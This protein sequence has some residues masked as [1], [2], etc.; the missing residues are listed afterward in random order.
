MWYR[1]P[2]AFVIVSVL[3]VYALLQSSTATLAGR[4]S[5]PGLE[6][7]VRIDRDQ[8]GVPLILAENETDMARALGF[9][10]GQERFFQMDLL[11]RSAAGELAALFGEKALEHD[12]DLRRHRFRARA[13]QNWQRLDRAQQALL[14][15]Y[16]AGVNAGL[17]E[18][19]SRPFEYWL[20]RQQ[21]QAWTV[22]DSLL[23]I[24][25]MYLD[26]QGTL[27]ARE[28]SLAYLNQHW[29]AELVDF[30]TPGGGTLD[31]PL[32]GSRL[33]LKAMPALAW[34]AE[35]LP[36][37]EVTI[38]DSDLL[39]GSNAWAVSGRLT[40]DGR[41]LLA[42]DMHLTLR[43]PNIWYRISARVGRQLRAGLT[44]PGAPA[45]VS[46]SNGHLAW[47]FT[48]AYGD[49]SDL[50]ALEL[51][52]QGHYRT[53]DG[54]EPLTKITE[55]IQVA[56]TEPVTL[57]V[58]ESRWGPV[59]GTLPDG[60]PYAQLWTAHQ[61]DG[62]NLKLLELVHCLDVSCALALAP[63]M[64]IPTQNLVL[65]DRRGNLAWIPAGP[66]P[67]RSGYDGL[68]PVSLADGDKTFALRLPASA[69]PR[70][71]NP[72]T[73][74]IWS[75]NQRMLGGAELERIGDGGYALGARAG[76]IRDRLYA[77]DSFDEQ[78]FFAIQHDDGVPLY[79]YWA[80]RLDAE[81]SLLPPSADVVKARRL[82]SSW[83]QRA[84]LEE[85]AFP[86]IKGFRQ[87]LMKRLFAPLFGLT[88]TEPR[89]DPSPLDNQLE[90]P[91]RQLLNARP[92]SML[93]PG[94]QSWDDLLSELTARLVADHAQA[95]WPT[96]GEQNLSAI[97]HPLSAALPPWLGRYLDAPAAPQSGDAHAPHVS[98]ARF[99]A[100]GRLVVVPGRE[101]NAILVMPGGQS[102]HPLSPYYLAGHDAWLEGSPQPLLAG[103][104]KWRLELQP[105][106]DH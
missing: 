69:Y 9:L 43:V 88:K 53:A 79:Q 45:L 91:L 59:M 102:G 44:L 10:H 101:E 96:W 60:R 52:E 14:Q 11:R 6:K 95:N 48:N 25:A 36:A 13:R 81:L 100:S 63:Q 22:E 82:V 46:G 85:R 73:G 62:V 98:G 80:T 27:E 41:A 57:T 104:A 103:Q 29:P 106:S 78:D 71:L 74:R 33:Q 40:E 42:N 54:S 66:L 105:A 23:V 7:P 20:L 8:L 17:N 1:W 86:L 70:R 19:A 92:D 94:Y 38:K 24:Y 30:L 35:L 47:G 77:R 4:L 75:A 31:A 3:S 56:G 99:G 21:P 2:I 68:A 32:D 26:L 28:W 58:E 93:P 64:G 34:P 87:A 50:V 90:Y 37:G 89:F 5:L 84:S 16:V 51:D 65:A 67:Q 49:F 61:E 12:R 39:P 83:Q 15:S 18:L 97:R 76:Q 55:T 72:A